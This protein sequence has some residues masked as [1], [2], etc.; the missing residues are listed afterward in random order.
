M[1]QAHKMLHK[2]WYE[3]LIQEFESEYFQALKTFLAKEKRENIIFPPHDMIFNAFNTTAIKDV[4]VVI[5]GQDPY[6]GK[7]QANGLAFS[8]SKGMKI[9]PSLRNIYKELRADLGYAIPE[10]GD[11]TS[12]AKQ[13]V[14]LMNATLTVRQKKA[15]SHQNKGWEKFTDAVIQ[16]ISSE[17]PFL[18]FLLWGNFAQSKKI[19]IDERKHCVLT[20]SHPSPFSAHNGFFGCRHFSRT[21]KLLINK[22]LSPINWEIKNDSVQTSLF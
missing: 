3:F 21:N 17:K 9:P 11:L 1:L 22:K 19:L 10:H 6:H 12:W 14:L 4:K 2:S 20:A 5:V 8:V 7:N 18:V 13:G 15:G 16:K